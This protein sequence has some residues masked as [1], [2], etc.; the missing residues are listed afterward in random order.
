MDKD[1]VKGKVNE[2]VGKATGDDSKELKGKLQQEAGKIKEKAEDLKDDV[3]SE[4]NK[5]FDKKDKEK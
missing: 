1:Q 4:I 5:L 2:T 3:A